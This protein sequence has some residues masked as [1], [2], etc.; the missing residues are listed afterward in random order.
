MLAIVCHGD[1]S[2]T[3]NETQYHPSVCAQYYGIV[4]SFCFPSQQNIENTEQLSN[5]TW[6]IIVFIHGFWLL[7]S[8]M[9]NQDNQ[10]IKH[11]YKSCFIV[12]ICLS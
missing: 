11:N 6:I 8:P 12:H 7:Y 1:S 2:F 10:H 5:K 4:S 3:T 9:S